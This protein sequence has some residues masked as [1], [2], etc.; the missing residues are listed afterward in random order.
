[1]IGMRAWG[2]RLGPIGATLVVAGLIGVVGWTF[3]I[4]W[5]PSTDTY[6]LQGVDVSENSGAIDWQTVRAGGADFAYLRAT[7]GADRRDARFADNWRQVYG[8]GLRRGAFHV[9]SLCHLAIDQA[10]NFVVTVPRTGDALPAAVMIDF[11]P[12]CDARPDRAV[13]AGEIRRFAA[14][15]ESHTGK[16][17]LI[18]VTADVESAYGLTAA[19]PRPVWASGNYFPPDYAARPWRMWRANAMRRIE[20]AAEPVGWNVVA[21]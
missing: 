5:R 16:P 15:V 19:I 12:D 13:L 17:V 8:A 9:F 11:T 2:R 21:R 1:M 4:S 18:G 3:A 7:E 10:N 6:P 14:V 20:G